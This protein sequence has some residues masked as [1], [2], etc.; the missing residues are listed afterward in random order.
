[1]ESIEFMSALVNATVAG[2]VFIG[3]CVMIVSF[4]MF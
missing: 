4:W 1:M 2:T 3:C